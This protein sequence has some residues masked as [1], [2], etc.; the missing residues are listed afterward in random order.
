[1]ESVF[2]GISYIRGRQVLFGVISL[3]MFAVL[4]GGVTALLPIYA[5]D[6]L[7]TGPWGLGLLRSAPAVGAL[8]MSATLSRFSISRR[9]GR[10]LF[11]SVAAYGAAISLFGLSTSLA[12]SLVALA[13]YG[14][15]D[16][17]SV[18]I[19]HSLVQTRTPNEMLGRVMAVNSMFTGTSGTLGEFRAGVMAAWWGAVPAVLIGGAGALAITFIWMRL[20]PEL[21]RIDKLVGDA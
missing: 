11:A 4:L 3:D 14:A 16:A 20:F 7:E 1:L 13:S 6:I 10:L 17:I 15:A 2:A 8:L 21:P 18:V 12:L 19:R 9:A 5:R